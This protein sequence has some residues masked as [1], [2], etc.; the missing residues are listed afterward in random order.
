MKPL[1]GVIFTLLLV[2]SPLSV[3]SH[4]QEA[5]KCRVLDANEAKELLPES[6][7][8]KTETIPVDMKNFTGLQFTDKTRVA[9]A[10]LI[11]SG[12]EPGIQKQYGFVLV[13]ETRMGLGNWTLPSGIIGLSV[14]QADPKSPTVT[15]V[16]RSVS[17]V[18]IE[19]ICLF[20]DASMPPVRVA[21]TPRCE[22]E[23]E[24]RIGSY[25]IIG[26]PR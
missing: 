25:A 26:W 11:N 13:S 16:A 20:F 15:L 9:I 5:P 3:S 8:L 2:V 7:L 24:L 19:R 18:V 17:G 4:S 1:K 12:C 23:F 22:N 6:V 21:L 14:E 10:P